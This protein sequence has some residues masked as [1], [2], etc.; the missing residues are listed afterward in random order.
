MTLVAALALAATAAGDTPITELLDGTAVLVSQGGTGSGATSSTTSYTH[1]FSPSTYADYHHRGGEPTVTVDRYPFTGEAATK[2]CSSGQTSCS[3]RDIVYYSAPQGFAF[4]QFS[5]FLKSDESPSGQSFRLPLHDPEFGRAVD[6]GKGGGDTYQVVGPLTHKVFFVDLPAQCVTLNTS[7]DLGQTFTD[8]ELG[9]GANPGTIDD[10]QWVE[11]DETIPPTSPACAGSP[12]GATCQNVYISFGNFTNLEAPTLSL[13]RSTHDGAEGTFVTDS[14]CNTLTLEG[15][16]GPVNPIPTVNPGDNVATACPD[17]ADNRYQVAGPVVADKYNTHNLYIPFVRSGP[18][19]FNPLTP[20]PPYDLYI[21]K[22]VDGGSTWTRKLVAHLG[23]HNPVNLFPDLTV[24]KA[25]NLYVTWAQ[26]AGAPVNAANPLE[27]TPDLGGETDIYYAYSTSFG[28]TWSPPISL[29]QENGDSAVMPW[30]VAGDAGQV[31]LVYY[32]SNSGLNPNVAET[33]NGQ[34]CNPQ[35]NPPVLGLPTC[36]ENA[37]PN[38]SAWNVIF[39]QSQN[40]LN[41]GSNFK[42]PQITDHPI[43]LGQVC[44]AGLFCTLSD[45]NRNLLDFITV[46][47]DHFG[48]AH[49]AW[50]DD[51]D[52]RNDRR[53]KYSRQLSGPSIFKNQNISL[54]SSWPITDHSVSDPFGDVRSALGM[55]VDC[56]SMDI[57]AMSASRSNDLL[58]LSLTLG[59]PPSSSTA[60]GCSPAVATGGIWGA[61]FWASALPPSGLAGNDNFYIAYR[62]N[63]PDGAAHGEAGRM[64]ALTDNRITNEPDPTQPATPGGTCLGP[65][66]PS[67]CTLTLTTTLSTLGIKSGAGLYSITGLS[68]YFFGAAPTDASKRNCP[69]HS[70]QADAS[71]ALIVPGTGTTG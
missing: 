13:A 60:I 40:A 33:D 35:E 48:A 24:D 71:A 26:T 58:T 34:P 61:E 9:C 3:A 42:K 68:L 25:G 31:D 49:V 56:P 45:G 6:Q 2:F 57:R 69:C 10:R 39:G 8:D 44:T 37:T 17:P 36:S 65:L 67:P 18:S 30:L 15:G 59:A 12:I 46:D 7:T 14:T 62:D 5:Y 19:A 43:H 20:V 23:D 64:D 50:T 47:V 11:A 22:S 29:T 55:P 41:T 21:A 54:Q 32:R 27:V 16:G 1:V 53:S 52:S 4:P 66:P 38:P 51:N 63:P 28:D 70:Q